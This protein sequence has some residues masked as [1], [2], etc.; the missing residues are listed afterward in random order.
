MFLDLQGSC[1]NIVPWPNGGLAKNIYDGDSHCNSCITRWFSK[2]VGRLGLKES[3]TD[4]C[5]NAC[6][7]KRK[8]RLVL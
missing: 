4:R 7:C 6:A 1:V 5:D 3:H 8:D 2:K